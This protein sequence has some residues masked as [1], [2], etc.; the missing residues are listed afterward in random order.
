M[1]KLND[2]QLEYFK[3]KLIKLRHEIVSN[4]KKM[5]NH[6]QQETRPLDGDDAV[7]QETYW[8][9]ECSLLNHEQNMLNAI[10]EALERIEQ[11][12][13]GYCED[14]QELISL[15]RL[16]AYPATTL[17]I[18]AQ[19]LYEKQRKILTGRDCDGYR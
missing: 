15:E 9:T 11:K 4:A 6:L 17:S 7:C 14:T 19:N 2:C 13:Y 12:T 18:A 5:L 10:D 1:R 16:E 3:Q 8:I